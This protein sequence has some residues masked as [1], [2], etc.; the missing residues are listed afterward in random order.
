MPNNI[1]SNFDKT[2]D[3]PLTDNQDENEDD[4]PPQSPRQSEYITDRA[5]SQALRKQTEDELFYKVAK[6]ARPTRLKTKFKQSTLD[7]FKYNTTQ[8]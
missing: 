6:Y 7:K 3:N 8:D 5:L 1:F 2:A 4:T